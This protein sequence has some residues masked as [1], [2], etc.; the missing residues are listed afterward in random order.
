MLTVQQAWRTCCAHQSAQAL[1]QGIVPHCFRRSH[2]RAPGTPPQ[3]SPLAEEAPGVAQR[4]SK[5]DCSSILRG[6]ESG[7]VDQVMLSTNAEGQRFVKLRVRAQPPAA[8]FWG[9]PLLGREGAQLGTLATGWAS[10]GAIRAHSV[11]KRH[12]CDHW[13]LDG[14]AGPLHPHPPGRRQ[15]RQPARAEG[16]HRCALP[17]T[18]PCARMSTACMRLRGRMHACPPHARRPPAWHGSM[19]AAQL[20]SMR[21]WDLVMRHGVRRLKGP[22]M[23]RA[24]A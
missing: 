13:V 2:A 23:L 16:H 17:P 19:L 24:Q 10:A 18:A 14:C 9:T 15:V 21:G 12:T 7:M 6:S 8:P 3:T 5:K 4:F 11:Y 22:G 1:S 20:C